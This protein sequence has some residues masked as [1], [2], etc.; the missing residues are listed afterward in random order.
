SR[1][2]EPV[3]RPCPAAG[4][5]LGEAVADARRVAEGPDPERVVDVLPQVAREVGLHHEGGPAR[6]EGAADLSQDRARAVQVVDDIEG[7]DQVVAAGEAPGRVADLVAD[8][9]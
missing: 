5:R 1:V 7:R 4:Q 9:L 8:A 2:A 6:L 3:P